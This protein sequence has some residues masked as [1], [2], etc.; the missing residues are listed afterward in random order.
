MA[1]IIECTAGAPW[2]GLSGAEELMRALRLAAA[3]VAGWTNDL[4]SAKD[5]LREDRD[6]LVTVLGRERGCSLPL[7]REQVI[8]M[9]DDRVREFHALAASL[10]AMAVPGTDWDEV[11]RYVAAL[12]SFVAATLHWLCVTHRFDAHWFAQAPGPV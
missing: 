1:D 2:P 5:D 10:T 3:D 4:V 11:R 6:N 9:R 12:R 7:A 8:G